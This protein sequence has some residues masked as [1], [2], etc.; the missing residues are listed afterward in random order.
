[1]PHGEAG[2]AVFSLQYYVLGQ[3]IEEQARATA[4]A[5]VAP[6]VGP[7]E[8]GEITS[9]VAAWDTLGADDR[10][11]YGLDLLLRGLRDRYP[12]ARTPAARTPAASTP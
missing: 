12:P 2:V 10:F 6:P 4:S 5:P 7:P 3:T 11:G 8:F 1:V 9:V